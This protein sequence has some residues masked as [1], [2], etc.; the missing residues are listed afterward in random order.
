MAWY[1]HR[2]SGKEIEGERLVAGTILTET[3]VYDSTDGNWL[4]CPCPGCAV[5][6]NDIIWDHQADNAVLYAG[7]STILTG[8][9]SNC[10][11]SEPPLPSASG[12]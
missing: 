5:V 4:I 10:S 11:I 6:D 2:I 1:K 7:K 8:N 9:W 3:D 12:S